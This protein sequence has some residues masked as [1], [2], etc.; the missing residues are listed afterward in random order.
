MEMGF[1][2]PLMTRGRSYSLGA[3]PS[4]RMLEVVPVGDFEASFVPTEKDFSRLDERF[5]LPAGTW[6]KL[7]DYQDYGFAVFKLKP[8]LQQ[9]HPMSFSFP[10][11]DGGSLFFPTVHIHDGKVHKKAEFDHVLYCQPREGE[12]LKFVR[13][14]VWEESQGHARNFMKPAQTQGVVDA[15]QHCYKRPLHGNLPNR[16]TVVQLDA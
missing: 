10:R 6:E 5:Q 7:P 1:V 8:G 4:D 3:I 14:S 2:R 11:R 15:D 16:D 9:L 12:P 13:G